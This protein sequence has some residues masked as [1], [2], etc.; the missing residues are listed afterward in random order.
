MLR[1]EYTRRLRMQ[2]LLSSIPD[3]RD[4]PYIRMFNEAERNPTIV[5]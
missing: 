3:P 1:R 4:G 2:V 5:T